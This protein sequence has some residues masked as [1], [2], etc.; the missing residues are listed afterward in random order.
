VPIVKAEPMPPVHPSVERLELLE[1]YLGHDPDNRGLLSEVVAAA[2]ES[3]HLARAEELLERLRRLESGPQVEHLNGLLRLAQ[4]RFEEAVASFELVA[5]QA[6][7]AAPARFNLGYALFRLGDFER[8]SEVFRLLL[9]EKNAPAETL[10]YLMRAMHHAGLPEEAVAAW[11]R[12][13]ERF[14]TP[15]ALGVASLAS[16]D[17]NQLEEA[18]RLSELALRTA[19]PPLE[20]FVVRGTLAVGEGRPEVAEQ[21]LREAATRSPDDGRVWS[22]VAA[23][24]MLKGELPSAL[25]A[26]AKATRLLPEHVGAWV[27]QAW[28]QILQRDLEAART[29]LSAAMEVN[30]NFAETHGTLAVVSALQGRRTEAERAIEV[31]LRLDEGSLSAR[32]AQAILRG[33]AADPEAVRLL[34]RRLLRGR[35]ELPVAGLLDKPLRNG[36]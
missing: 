34:A 17:S 9:D 13:G 7:D 8:A 24:R 5:A 14:S 11:R 21:M 2:V 26:F 6:A 18:A 35:M 19:T 16:L 20:A 3:G 25:D 30:R 23:A 33:D 10:T 29:S 1:S 22:A 4:H 27:A 12:A 32:Y 28:C 36:P 31:A 15:Q